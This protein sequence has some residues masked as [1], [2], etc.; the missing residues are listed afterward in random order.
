VN[1]APVGPDAGP[2]VVSLPWLGSGLLAVS[3]PSAT[4]DPV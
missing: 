4:A 3:A 2:L 1:K